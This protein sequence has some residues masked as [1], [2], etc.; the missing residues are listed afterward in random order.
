[1]NYLEIIVATLGAFVLGWIWYGPLFGKKWMEL[2]GMTMEKMQTM[3]MKPA[4]AMALGFVSFLFV[5]Y[6]FNWFIGAMAIADVAGAM[7]L[8][9]FAWL[10]FAMPIHAGVWIWEGRSFSLFAFNAVYQLISF[11]IVASILAAWV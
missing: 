10:G 11:G 4:H 6:V 5:A 3:G 2:S 7:S 1:M 9:F 8:A